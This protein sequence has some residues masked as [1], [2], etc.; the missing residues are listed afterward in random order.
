VPRKKPTCFHRPKIR[1]LWKRHR[2]ACILTW[3]SS[4]PLRL[5]TAEGRSGIMKRGWYSY[6]GGFRAGFSPDFPRHVKTHRCAAKAVWN[7]RG[8]APRR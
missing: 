6:S 5:P 1:S 3:A 8:L 4:P 2:H 7:R